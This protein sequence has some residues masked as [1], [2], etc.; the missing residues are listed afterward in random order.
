LAIQKQPKDI[1]GY[2]ALA[3][4]YLTQKNDEQ[5]FKVVRAGIAAQPDSSVL[6]LYLADMHERKGDYEAAISE[7]ESMLKKEP[8]S[9][10][11]S[12][13]LASM[14]ADHRAD[15]ASLERAQALAVGLR[16]SPIPQFKD[17]LGWVS[18]Q[19][20]EFKTAVSLL[21]E[22]VAA[23]PDQPLIEYHL[24]MT[25][26]AVGQNEKA[27]EQLKLA[28]NGATDGELKEKIQIALKKAGT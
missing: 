12:N 2:R 28:L 25:Y 4:F 23:V 9:L 19:M 26:I 8:G 27:L 18:Y 24:G 15:K 17:T 20:G 11:A 10:V 14:L 22:A 1:I 16:K 5:A 3:N 7:Y 21:E 13:N 6:H